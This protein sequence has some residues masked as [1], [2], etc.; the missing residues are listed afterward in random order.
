M[1]GKIFDKRKLYIPFD[2]WYLKIKLLKLLNRNLF[3]N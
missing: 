1:S 2:N 3:L